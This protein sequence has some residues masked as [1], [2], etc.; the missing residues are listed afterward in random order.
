MTP[1]DFALEVWENEGGLVDLR[2]DEDDESVEPP[3]AEVGEPV[4][5]PA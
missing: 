5:Q 1:E 4:H 2:L 3:V